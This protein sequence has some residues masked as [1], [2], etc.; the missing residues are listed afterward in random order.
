MYEREEDVFYY[1]TVGN[2][3]YPQPPMPDGVEEGILKGVYRYCASDLTGSRA[4]AHLF[5]SGAILNEVVKAQRILG[6]RFGI[7]ADV[8]SITSYKQLVLDGQTTERWNLLHPMEKP[9]RPYLS[10]VLEGAE[11]VYVA[12]SDYLKTLPNSVCRWFPKPVAALGT[13][14]FGRSEGRA[15]LRDFFEVD[16]RYIALAALAELAKEERV[17]AQTVQQAIHELEINLEKADP[18]RS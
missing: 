12:A 8:W 13:D 1:L 3:N 17:P 18:A 7:A 2:E 15:A 5:G 14:G 6:E 9:R 4:R 10:Q 11:G 16:A